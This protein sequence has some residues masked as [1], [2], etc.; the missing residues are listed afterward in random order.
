MCT[1]LGADKW[2]LVGSELSRYLISESEPTSAQEVQGASEDQVLVHETKIRALGGSEKDVRVHAAARRSRTGNVVGSVV[3]CEDITD[4]KKAETELQTERIKLKAITDAALD[5][6]VMADSKGTVTFWNPAAERVFGVS[7]QQAVGR[8][9]VDFVV[10]SEARAAVRKG[11]S[12]FDTTGTHSA[13]ERMFESHA[14]RSDGVRF[15]IE[16]TQA[17]VATSSGNNVVVV[18]RDITER[19]LNEALQA[20][21]HRELELY[22]SLLRHDL[23]NDLGVILSNLELAKAGPQAQDQELLDPLKSIEAASN[24]MMETLSIFGRPA[25][26]AEIDLLKLVNRVADEAMMAHEG[27]QIRVKEP[28]EGMPIL[29]VGSRLFPLVLENI[30]GNAAIHAGTSTHIEV[31]IK[32]TSAHAEIV[33]SDD[34]PGIA[35]EV[36][37]RLFE[38]GASTRGGGMGLYL[39]REVVTSIGGTLDLEE[40]SALGGAAF[41]ITVPL[42]QSTG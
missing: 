42:M 30:F 3:I 32:A 2:A 12:E 40:H 33:I 24:R 5:A 23:K 8:S 19:K 21:A 15:P 26:T 39:S 28:S 35:R 14:M 36:K 16:M 38:R 13:L 41:K 34:G 27:I 11:V 22:A 17:P 6:I 4:H 10:P 7:R 18:A 1:V 20:Q 29:I 37:G 25:E 9:F 31:D